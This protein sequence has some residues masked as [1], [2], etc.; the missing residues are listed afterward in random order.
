[1]AYWQNG[2]RLEG[3]PTWE[4]C[5]SCNYNLHICCLCGDDLTHAEAQG[6]K[7]YRECRPDL[8]ENEETE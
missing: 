1:M 6:D 4:V 8:Y 2:E 5:D 7:H 3:P